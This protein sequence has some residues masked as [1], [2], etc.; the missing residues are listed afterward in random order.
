MS[1]NSSTHD[2]DK[3]ARSYDWFMRVVLLIFGTERRIRRKIDAALS[4]QNLK[5]GAKILEVGCGTGA[6]LKVIDDARPGL[7]ELTGLDSSVPMLE[8]ARKKKFTSKVE[9]IEGDAATLPFPAE[10]FDS[11]LIVLVL[12]EMDAGTRLKATTEILRV[13]KEKGCVLVVDFAYPGNILG[14]VVFP[15]LRTTE[16]EE[17][18]GFAR[19]GFASLFSEPV[20][21]KQTE[22]AIMLGL[23]K[24]SLYKKQEE[25]KEKREESFFFRTLKK[26]LKFTRIIY[27]LRG[28]YDV[29]IEDHSYRGKGLAG[30]L[31]SGHPGNGE[32]RL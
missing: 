13:L 7:F 5:K 23:M 25:R 15:L 4:C 8:E 29:G 10:S 2:F 18:L 28:T 16:S 1:T 17:A 30:C 9:F 6:N 14:K 26:V 24:I 21:Q 27:R 20:F 19:A 11:A 32:Q 22:E 12:H 3:Y 31:V